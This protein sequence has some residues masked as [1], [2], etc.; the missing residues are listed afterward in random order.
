MAMEGLT[1]RRAKHPH[2]EL[3]QWDMG[4]AILGAVCIVGTG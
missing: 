4:K 1:M 3:A 2:M